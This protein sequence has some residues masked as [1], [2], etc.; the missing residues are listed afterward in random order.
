MTK[1]WFKPKSY[2]YGFCPISKEGW[3]ATL[4]LL[5]L[6]LLSAWTNDFFVEP[7]PTKDEAARFVLDVF[8]L[9]GLATIF[10]E[11]KMKEPLQWRWGRKKN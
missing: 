7:G 10:F 8:I 5:A 6:L 4:A 2:G 9:G 1:Y 11:K 3:L